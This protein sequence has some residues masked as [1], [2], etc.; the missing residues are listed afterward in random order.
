MVRNA[1][2][3]VVDGPLNGEL[4]ENQLEAWSIEDNVKILMT[5]KPKSNTGCI[6]G[7]EM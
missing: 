5:V 3:L 7:F 2:A 4:V 1:F 6:V